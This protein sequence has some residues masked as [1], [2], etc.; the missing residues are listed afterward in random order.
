MQ[1]Y[2]NKRKCLNEKCNFHIRLVWDNCSLFLSQTNNLLAPLFL[3]S[4]STGK[5]KGVL[6]TV[7]GYMIYTA[8]TFK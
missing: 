1:I 3:T 8:T 7:G 4:G 6:H 2:W 5:P